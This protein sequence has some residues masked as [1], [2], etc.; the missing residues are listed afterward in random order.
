MANW[1]SIYL[2]PSNTKAN[3]DNRTGDNRKGLIGYCNDDTYYG[4]LEL[5]KYDGTAM[6]PMAG[7]KPE[8]IWSGNIV[9]YSN[10]V[11]TVNI[12][13]YKLFIVTHNSVNVIAIKEDLSSFTG[14]ITRIIGIY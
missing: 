6:I 10:I 5:I 13:E 3:F 1:S 2:L 8:I 7:V 12:D 11:F 14:T 4:L 9:G